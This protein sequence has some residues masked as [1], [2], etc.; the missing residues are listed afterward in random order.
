MKIGI[1]GGTFNPI[2]LGH[3]ILAEEV[4]QK[5]GLQKLVFVPTN[6]PPHKENGTIVS[7]A[8]R[9]KMLKLAIRGNSCFSVSDLEIKR[10][11][12]S[13]TIDTLKQFRRIYKGDELYFIIG[14]DLFKYLNEWKDLKEIISL[15]KFIVATR[16]GYPLENLPDYIA[17][18]DIRAVDISAFEVR[19]CIKNQSSFRY[20]VPEPVRSYII[21]KRLYR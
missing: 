16:P 21:R 17:T 19:Q 6:L 8:D 15:V 5:V 1:F 7:A 9:L 20:L 14:S 3:L 4:R 18:I 2:H 11:G 12:R 13:Y 10:G